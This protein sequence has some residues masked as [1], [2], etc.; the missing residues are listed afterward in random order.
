MYH[1]LLFHLTIFPMLKALRDLRESHRA[2]HLTFCAFIESC[3]TQV[4]PLRRLAGCLPLPLG[5]LHRISCGGKGIRSH[6]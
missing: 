2:F 1:L 3:M 5:S 6:A 4:E